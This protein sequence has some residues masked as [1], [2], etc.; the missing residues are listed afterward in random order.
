MT[1][2]APVDH[3]HHQSVAVMLDDFIKYEVDELGNIWESWYNFYQ[4]ETSRGRAPGRIVAA[5]TECTE[6]AGDHLRIVQTLQWQGPPEW[7]TP[8]GFILARET[9]TFDVFPGEVA[10][11]IDISSQLQ[12]T[13]WDIRI[14][15]TVHGYFVMRMADGLRPVDGGTLI[16]SEGRVGAGEVRGRTADWADC[17]GKAAYGKKA[18][19]AVFPYPPAGGAP[20]HLSD[21]GFIMAN[22]FQVESKRVNRGETAEAVVWLVA[23]DGDAAEAQVQSLYRVFGGQIA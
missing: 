16:D 1:A 9:R 19:L 18:G 15:G 21:W 14:G 23:H 22:P 3:P 13:G 10:N 8:D 17:S 6:I 2:E 4:D 12:P 20:W 7:S 5:S 11:V